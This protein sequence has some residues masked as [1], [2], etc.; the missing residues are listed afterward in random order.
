[1]QDN[2]PYQRPIK[3][4]GLW[5]RTSAAGKTYLTGRLAGA[6]LLVVENRDRQ[7]EGGR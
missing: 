7:T 4:T 3:L 2:R 6:K 1:M 5:Q